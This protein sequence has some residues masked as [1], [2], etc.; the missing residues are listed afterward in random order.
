MNVNGTLWKTSVP[1]WC[2]NLCLPHFPPNSLENTSPMMTLFAQANLARCDTQNPPRLAKDATHGH[3]GR[4]P[5]AWAPNTARKHWSR[6][7]KGSLQPPGSKVKG[8]S[9]VDNPRWKDFW[10]KVNVSNGTGSQRLLA[11]RLELCSSVIYLYIFFQWPGIRPCFHCCSFK[12]GCF[13]FKIRLQIPGL[14]KNTNIWC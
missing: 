13:W 11:C 5:R 3:Y 7:E 10:G 2:F 6:G 12:S 8:C 1:F 4:P 9:K 14:Q